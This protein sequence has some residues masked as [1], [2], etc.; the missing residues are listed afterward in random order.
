[1]SILSG[2]DGNLG[3]FSTFSNVLTLW[4]SQGKIHWNQRRRKVRSAT[5]SSKLSPSRLLGPTERPTQGPGTTAQKHG[6]NFPMTTQ[7][8]AC[9]G[10]TKIKRLQHLITE[11]EKASSEKPAGKPQKHSQIL[12]FFVLAKSHQHCHH[13]QQ[14]TVGQTRRHFTEPFAVVPSVPSSTPRTLVPH[15]YS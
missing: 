9:L 10:W 1:M 5:C 12:C 15:P 7:S 4:L 11:K 3:S 14:R 8:L 2:P 13:H 6:R